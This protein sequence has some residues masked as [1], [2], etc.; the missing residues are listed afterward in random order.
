PAFA[1]SSTTSSSRQ[2]FACVRICSTRSW[3]SDPMG[4]FLVAVIGVWV[5]V[6]G[7]WFAVNKWF[8]NADADRMKSRI[9]ETEEKKQKKRA[10]GIP[11]LIRPEDGEGGNRVAREILKH[12]DLTKR[13]A[14][15]LEQAGLR[16]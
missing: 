6:L 14:K 4:I 13:V 3:R 9:L 12:L 7:I 5:L 15:L 1:L 10:P 16:W 2:G 8:R 11:S